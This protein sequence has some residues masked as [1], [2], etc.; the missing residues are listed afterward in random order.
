MSTN[1]RPFPINVWEQ[2]PPSEL[3]F[4]AGKLA[5]TGQWLAENARGQPYR[6]VVVRH[7]Y[8]AAEWSEE[9]AYDDQLPMW[10]AAKSVY[11]RGADCLPVASVTQLDTRARPAS[12]VDPL[13]GR[14]N[15][16]DTALPFRTL[17]RV[18]GISETR[19]EDGRRLHAARRIPAAALRAR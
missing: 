19:H 17:F 8:L 15:R 7:G 6:V 1:E 16:V 3:G 10:S 13:L 2:R 4:D 9:V 14:V 11:S 12:Q 5:A 18:W